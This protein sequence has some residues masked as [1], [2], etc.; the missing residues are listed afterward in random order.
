MTLVESLMQ[1]KNH[2][3]ITRKKWIDSGITIRLFSSAKIIEELDITLTEESF[4]AED[5]MIVNIDNK[6]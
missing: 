1:C 3:C 4:F 6:E 2:E 5:W